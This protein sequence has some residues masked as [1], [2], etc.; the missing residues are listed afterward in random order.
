[1]QLGAIVNLRSYSM[2][3]P[4][5]SNKFYK[6]WLI[7]AGLTFVSSLILGLPELPGYEQQY[8]YLFWTIGLLLCGLIFGSVIYLLYRLISGNWNNNV[9]MICISI[10]LLIIILKIRRSNQ[11]NSSD[12][13][14]SFKEQQGQKF[15]QHLDSATNVYANFK[16]HIAFDG[17]V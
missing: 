8:G 4:I 2:A 9:F 1:M 7:L 12:F 3:H 14:K 15:N 13:E 10:T 17:P 5:F 16:Y 11:N 6:W